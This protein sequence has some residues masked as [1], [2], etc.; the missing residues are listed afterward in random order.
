MCFTPDLYECGFNS[1][2]SE[3]WPSTR[4]YGAEILLALIS[5]VGPD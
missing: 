1:N 5:E 3:T 4:I 2:Q